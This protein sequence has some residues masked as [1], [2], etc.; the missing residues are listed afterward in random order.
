MDSMESDSRVTDDVGEDK[1]TD[2]NVATEEFHR[3]EVGMV[4]ILL[5]ESAGSPGGHGIISNS[6]DGE[7]EYADDGCTT[8]TFGLMQGFGVGGRGKDSVGSY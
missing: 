2:W 8:E 3:T 1:V 7:T 5:I 6:P 4:E